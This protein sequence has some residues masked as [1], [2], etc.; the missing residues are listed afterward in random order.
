MS[1]LGQ[2]SVSE[3]DLGVHWIYSGSMATKQRKPK[4]ERKE[5][6]LRLRLTAA[7]HARFTG[8]AKRVGLDLSNWLRT[9]ATRAAAGSNG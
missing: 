9:V 6:S 2:S 4:A 1:A 3:L 7:Q 8:A 5:H